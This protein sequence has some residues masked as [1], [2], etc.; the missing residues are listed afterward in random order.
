M[1][2]Q[3]RNLIITEDSAA[4]ESATALSCANDA[5]NTR[6]TF[7]LIVVIVAAILFLLFGLSYWQGN[8][9]SKLNDFAKCLKDKGVIFYGAF[10]CPH[11]QNMKSLFGSASQYLPYIECST[12]DSNGQLPVCK[13]AKIESYP[14][15]EFKDGSRQLGEVTLQQLSDKSGCPLPN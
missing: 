10:W 8:S 14:T 11:C 5:G 4:H 12:P 15:W 6:F 9:E 3:S 7:I 13:D 2:K 1:E